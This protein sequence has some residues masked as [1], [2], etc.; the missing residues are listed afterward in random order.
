MTICTSHTP[1]LPPLPCPD[2][3]S[4][5]EDCVLPRQVWQQSQEMPSPLY[6]QCVGKRTGRHLLAAV[7]DGRT[8]GLLFITDSLSGRRFLCDTGA[9]MSALPASATDIRAGPC[10]PPLLAANGSTIHTFGTR[11]VTVSFAGQR[12]TWDFVSAKVSTPLLGADFL[13]ANKLL[14]DV[15]NRRLVHAETFGSF[16]CEH[17]DTAPT[18]LSSA[19]S[20][21]DDFSHLLKEFSDIT[22]PTFSSTSAKHGV[23]HYISTNGPPVHAKARRL[24]PHKLSI[25]RAEFDAMERLGIVRRSNSPWASPLHLVPK[26]NG[27]WRPCGDYRRLNAVTT[28][29]RYPIP[30]IHDFSAH[31]AGAS[32][33]SKVDLVRGYHQV[34]VQPQDIPKTAV[35]TPFGLFEFL[36]MPF[37]L[38]NA[39]Q[40]FQRL[41]DTVLR[42]L[43]FVFVY[44]DDILVASTSE[45]EHLSHLRLLFSRLQQHGAIPL[46]SKVEAVLGLPQPHT[47]KALQEFCGMV[48]FYHRF[49]PRAADLMRPLYSALKGKKTSKHAL[50]WSTDML[51]AFSA[52]KDAL[53]DATMLAHPVPDAPVALTT[54]AS[55]YAVGAVLQQ[56]VNSVWQ[57]L[58]FFSRQLRSSEQKY[59]TFDRELLALYLAI[60][61][62]RFLLEARPF[63]AFVDHKP[64][65]FAMA[66]VSEPWSARQQRHLAFI[67]EFTVADCLSRVVIGAVHLGIDYARMAVD[68]VSDPD[69]QAYRTAVTG[70]QLADV[71]FGDAGTT[72][73]CD[74]SL[75]LPR[76]VVPQVWRRQVFDAIHGLSHP[77]SKP[78]QR[79]VAA[80]FV[81][82]GLKKDIRD[83]VRTCVACQRAKI[84]RHVKAPLEQFAVPE[85]RFDHV[86]VDLVGPLPPSRGF[87][88]LLT[89]VDRTTR[90]PEVVPLSAT[91]SADVAR[92]FIGTWVARYG[93]PSDLSSDRGP[94]FTS[95]LWN[96]VACQL[97][98][99][100]HRTTAYHPQANGMCERFHRDM[101][102]AL[103]ASLTD[104]GWVD[105]LPWVMLGI[106]TAPKEDLLSSSAELVYG[107]TLRVPGEFIPRTTVPWSASDQRRSLMD[108]ARTFL[109]VPTS[110]H[111]LPQVHIPPDLRAAGLDRVSVDRLKPAHL[112][113]GRSVE[114]AQAPRRG[115]PP[116]CQPTSA[117]R[118]QPAVTL[119]LH[120]PPPAQELRNRFGRQSELWRRG[121]FRED[122]AVPSRTNR[123]GVASVVDE[124]T[125]LLDL[126]S[127][128]G[129]RVNP[130]WNRLKG[131]QKEKLGVPSKH[132]DDNITVDKKVD[133]GWGTS[134]TFPGKPSDDV[135]ILD[136]GNNSKK[137]FVDLT[138]PPKLPLDP[139]AHVDSTSQ[140]ED[141]D[142]RSSFVLPSSHVIDQ[143]PPVSHGHENYQKGANLELS[144]SY[145]KMEI[146]SSA[147]M[148]SCIVSNLDHR[149]LWVL[150]GRK[151]SLENL[152]CL[153]SKVIRVR[154]ALKGVQEKGVSKDLQDHQVYQAFTFGGTLLMNGLPSRPK[155]VLLDHLERLAR[156]ACGALLVNQGNAGDQGCQE[157]RFCASSV[158]QMSQLLPNK[159]DINHSC[160]KGSKDQGA[161]EEKPGPRAETGKMEEMDSLGHLVSRGYRALGVTGVSAGP[162]GKTVMRVYLVYRDHLVLL[163]SGGLLGSEVVMVQKANV[164]LM[165]RRALQDVSEL[166]ESMAQGVDRDK[167]DKVANQDHW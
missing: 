141:T 64:L 58:A 38:K 117:R 163:G 107:Q 52:T 3:Q 135:I 10:A 130:S 144:P 167:G 147:P 134:S 119:P 85:R 145:L 92:A 14:V 133:S 136:T 101:K 13:F 29:D 166:K 9:H 159:R 36:R 11:T 72:L 61:H 17:S 54:D 55:D 150:P 99:S 51:A 80:K 4:S 84:H 35:I 39:A 26:P 7:G 154:L 34:P 121:G 100:L 60:R 153:G 94:Q 32:I 37:G 50:S 68:Q 31:L 44:L 42:D 88:H 125:D 87:T 115:R 23:S 82:H 46:P 156:L 106:R 113:L 109:P 74:V 132:L 59:S 110:H 30:H 123:R 91:T 81:W 140:R 20:P 73:L 161:L 146:W 155:K 116:H 131:N 157:R 114:V 152:A 75:D 40:T 126:I 43:S 139:E 53:A 33:F 79:L 47:V 25:A 49:V 142:E 56:L 62:F 12:F 70:L 160:Q 66:K 6:I 98:V 19:L 151:A 21:A 45:A 93:A 5:Q 122:G 67:S 65:T 57:P 102:A 78:S 15:R 148:A 103:K 77:G 120:P 137:S 22:A 89:M 76:P 143:S 28:P 95:E 149:A 1:S 129:G 86:N 90:W 69:I 2:V 138:S 16:P 164:D 165:V 112:D 97:G 63:T 24:D 118:Q 83:W 105:K 108:T 128:I 71:P 162:K 48:N 41:M 104:D 111:C 96:T 27:G 124:D 127:P 8:S 18:K 158:V